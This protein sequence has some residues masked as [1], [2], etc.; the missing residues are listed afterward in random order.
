MVKNRGRVRAK[1]RRKYERKKERKEFERFGKPVNNKA[2]QH[3]P[4]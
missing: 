2:T 4:I 1:S 3:N